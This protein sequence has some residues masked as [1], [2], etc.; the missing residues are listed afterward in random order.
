MATTTSRRIPWL[1]FT[2]AILMVL[3][4]CLITFTDLAW[5]GTLGWSLLFAASLL[6][7]TGGARRR[8]QRGRPSGV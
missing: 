6:T 3:A 1:Y 7:V 4:A 2:G 5:R 8:Q